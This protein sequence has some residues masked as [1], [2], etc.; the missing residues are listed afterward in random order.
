MLLTTPDSSRALPSASVTPVTRAP[1]WSIRFTWLPVT[2]ST[3]SS[4]ASFSS[5]VGTARVPP[6]GYQTPSCVCIWAMPHSTAG[7]PAGLLPTY[8]Q[9]WS[10][11]CATFGSFT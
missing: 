4:R 9:K 5:A 1:S 2:I 10:T 6:M 11:I 8:W 7:D 3:P